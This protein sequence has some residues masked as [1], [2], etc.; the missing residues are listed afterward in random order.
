MWQIIGGTSPGLA[1]RYQ[2]VIMYVIAGSA[3]ASVVSS[4]LL[5]VLCLTDQEHRVRS[6]RL[7]QRG[8]QPKMLTKVVSALRT[9]VGRNSNSNNVRQGQMGDTSLIGAKST[10]VDPNRGTVSPRP[11]EGTKYGAISN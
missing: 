10:A 6:E 8:D 4:T 7:V 5:T 3:C 1:A 2:L 11:S 9:A